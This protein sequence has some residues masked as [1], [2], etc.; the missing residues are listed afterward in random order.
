MKG[1]LRIMWLMVF[2]D[3]PVTEASERKAATQFRN[4]LLRDGYIMLQFSVYAR[5]CYTQEAISKHLQRV[6]A[7][8]PTSGS[9]RALMVTDKQYAR[10][11]V[12]LGKMH[13]EEQQG[14]QQLLFF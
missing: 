5:P 8:T 7:H 10:M 2:F 6:Q 1:D 13:I 4:F 12:L 14:G 9:I 11:R 3:L